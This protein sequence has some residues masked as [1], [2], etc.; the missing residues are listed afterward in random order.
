MQDNG[1]LTNGTFTPEHPVGQPDQP[2]PITAKASE[3]GNLIALTVFLNG[4]G[5]HWE[6]LLVR[7]YNGNM[8]LAGRKLT[9]VFVAA[10]ENTFTQVEEPWVITK[11]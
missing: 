2:V 4:G 9:P 10:W 1:I 5:A 7:D 11:P 6:G 8:T 3:I